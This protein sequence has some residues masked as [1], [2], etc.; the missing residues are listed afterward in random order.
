MTVSFC[1]LP[2]PEAVGIRAASIVIGRSKIARDSKGRFTVAVSGGSTPLRLFELLGAT[3]RK[4]IEWGR[5][6]IFWVDER[7][8]PPDHKD[9]N[10]KGAHDALL[11]RVDIPPENVHRIKGEISPEEGARE[12]E[13]EL[14]RCFGG[15]G[16]P[17]FDLVI[18][19]VGEDGHTASLFPDAPSLSE[20]KRVAIPVYVEKLQSWRIT[21]TLPVLNNAVTVLFLVTGRKKAGIVKEILGNGKK[22]PEYPASLIQPVS[23]EATWLLDSEASFRLKG[24]FRD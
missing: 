17:E 8:V 9:S 10:Y 15:T 14:L 16:L 12:Y 3:F 23:G 4:D 21:L 13:K 22:S 7:C 11:S 24:M 5:T 1:S 6:E 18:L 2:D 20:G 19:G